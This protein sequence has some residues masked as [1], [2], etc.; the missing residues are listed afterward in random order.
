MLQLCPSLSKVQKPWLTLLKIKLEDSA[1]IRK[2]QSFVSM[3]RG[4][5]L[6]V[7]QTTVIDFS[8]F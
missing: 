1:G 7:A 8:L 3:L 6:I 2:R 4:K 5:G